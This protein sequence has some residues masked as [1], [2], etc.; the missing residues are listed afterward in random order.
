MPDSSKLREKQIEALRTL[1]AIGG[2]PGSYVSA[3][4]TDLTGSMIENLQDEGLVR[5]KIMRTET[6]AGAYIFRISDIYLTESGRDWLQTNGEK[7]GWLF[8]WFRNT[9]KKIVEEKSAAVVVAIGTA[10]LTTFVQCAFQQ[11]KGENPEKQPLPSPPAHTATQPSP[12]NAATPTRI[13]VPVT[14][15]PTKSEQAKKSP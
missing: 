1:A 5:C 13:Q 15:E 10:I 3:G 2:G 11:P 6:P 14:S 8:V 12:G 9:R 4:P 7:W